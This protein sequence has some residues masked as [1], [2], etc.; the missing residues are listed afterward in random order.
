MITY[1]PCLALIGVLILSAGC[2]TADNARSPEPAQADNT[3][4]NAENRAAQTA[5]DQAENDADLQIS[6]DIRKSIVADESLSSN[7][8][9]VKIITSGGTV[10]LRGPVKSQQEKASIESKA[11]QVTGVTQIVSLLEIE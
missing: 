5:P 10:T 6:A 2:I 3:A 8:H 4:R 7:A 11:K 1:K 9:N